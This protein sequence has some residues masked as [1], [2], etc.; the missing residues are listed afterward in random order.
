MAS[1]KFYLDKRA[2]RK[3]DKFPLKISVSNKQEYAL[4][5]LDVL[6]ST[7]QWDS[8]KNIVVNH[9][10]RLFLNNFIAKQKINIETEVLNLKSSGGLSSMSGKQIKDEIHKRLNPAEENNNKLLFAE[11]FLKFTDGKS[12]PRTQETYTYTLDKVKAFS[13]ADTLTF[14]DVNRTWLKDFEIFLSKTSSVN[15]ISIHMRNIRAVFNDALA[16][17][18]ITC[19]PFRKY[20]IKQEKT[21][22]RSMS[23]ENLVK[24]KNY[25]VEEHQQQYRDM[26][27]LIFYFIGINVIDLFSLTGSNIVNGR[28]EYRRAK[29]KRLYS[30]K[31][32]PEAAELLERYKGEKHLLNV[33]DNYR[34]YKDYAHRLNENL[35]QIGE[36]ERKGLGGKK[37]RKPL[38]PDLT[39]YWARH[40][41]ATI[42]A[43][44]EI[45]KETIA[46]ALGHGEDT[47]TDI[48]ID[49]DMNKVDEANR[50]VLDYIK[51]YG[52]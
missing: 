43:S 49:F 46:A 36:V 35:Q 17:E 32:E 3:D 34:N 44:L 20:K 39:T 47:V 12:N 18:L 31:I 45:P 13:N 41:W 40:T 51:N 24:L 1:I 48:Y 22:K 52:I 5:S 50:K 27:M 11:R 29:T 25:L 19:Y 16:D 26:F 9:P 8:K 14:E 30:I 6:L 33:L 23:V 4:I 21:K 28:L 37:E 7:E 38:F 10:N 15:S 42:A 2:K